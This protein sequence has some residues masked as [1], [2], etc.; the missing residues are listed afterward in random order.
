[1]RFFGNFAGGVFARRRFFLRWFGRRRLR[2]SRIIPLSARWRLFLGGLPRGI[3]RTEWP[4]NQNFR[5]PTLSARRVASQI[6]MYRIGRAGK[7]RQRPAG[8]RKNFFTR[9][10]ESAE[11]IAPLLRGTAHTA[12]PGFRRRRVCR[13][14]GS[15]W[16]S[17]KPLQYCRGFF[18]SNTPCRFPKGSFR[19]RLYAA[20]LLFWGYGGFWD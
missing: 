5:F 18:I 12:F 2:I 7:F 4:R 9:M 20:L 19:Y 10:M 16:H 17:A 14:D 1:M 3:P 13:A 8:H 15:R 6:L 11:K